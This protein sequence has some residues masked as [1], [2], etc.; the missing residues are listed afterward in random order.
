MKRKPSYLTNMLIAILISLVVS[1]TVI[2]IQLSFVKKDYEHE[3]MV[4]HQTRSKRILERGYEYYIAEDNNKTQLK[5]YLGGM[6]EGVNGSYIKS[7]YSD[8]V[9]A[10]D[11]FVFY[12]ADMNSLIPEGTILLNEKDAYPDSNKKHIYGFYDKDL[13]MRLQGM[14]EEYGYDIGEFVFNLKGAYIVDDN[15]FF[16]E[17]II[18]YRVGEGGAKMDEQV[19][20]ITDITGGDTE[21]AGAEYLHVDE[22]FFLCDALISSDVAYISVKAN[23]N[24]ARVNELVKEASDKSGGKLSDTFFRKDLNPATMELFSVQKI[25][26]GDYYAVCYRKINILFDAYSYS[27]FGGRGVLYIEVYVFEAFV[28]ILLFIIASQIITGIRI[29]K[30]KAA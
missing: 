9:I 26:E 28:I 6:V 25:S 18:C 22:N 7:P 10:S 30:Y 14:I 1:V 11:T 3:F 2:F 4:S 20:Y 16:P 13:A 21:H 24:M 17:R 23:G 19:L 29:K 15:T 5:Y 12:D 27:M 8:E